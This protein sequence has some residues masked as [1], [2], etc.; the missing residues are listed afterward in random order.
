MPE[1]IRVRLAKIKK[2]EEHKLG[3]VYQAR[4]DTFGSLSTH[5]YQLVKTENGSFE[6]IGL[7]KNSSVLGRNNN[8]VLTREG[9]TP[10]SMGSYERVAD[11]PEEY[12]RN[13]SGS[14][15]IIES[16]DGAS[17]RVRLPAAF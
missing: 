5:V 4:H 11:S 7:C 2:K 3:G 15:R 10:S 6:L 16:M 17:F 12:F 13:V 9:I 1:D 14:E 8:Y